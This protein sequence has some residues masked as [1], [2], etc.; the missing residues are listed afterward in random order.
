MLDPVTRNVDAA[1]DPNLVMTLHV[2]EESLERTAPTGAAGDPA[3][4][5]DRHHLGRA[6]AFVVE[7]VEG[8]S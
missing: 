1:A 4:Q 6:F 2:I 5:S 8:V 7:H 3:M